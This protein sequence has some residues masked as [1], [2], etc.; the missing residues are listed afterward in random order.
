MAR[1]SESDSL[2]DILVRTRWLPTTNSAKVSGI[3]HRYPTEP[4]MPEMTLG[5]MAKLYGLNRSSLYEAVAKGRVSA[6]LNAQGQK[7]INLAEMIRVYGEPPNSN[8]TPNTPRPTPQPDTPDSQLLEEIRRQTAVIE[9]MS[10][11]IERLEQALLRLP[12]PEADQTA[13]EPVAVAA[14]VQET[15]KRE[16]GAKPPPKDFTDLLRR[17]EGRDVES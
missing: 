15:P 13:P 11:R 4:D 9:K 10:Q 6:G 1:L 2:A 12:A 8:P 14:P 7:V 16:R 3:R 5:R 17:F